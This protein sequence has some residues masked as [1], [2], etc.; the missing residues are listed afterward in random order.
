LMRRGQGK[1][2]GH[3]IGLPGE[4]DWIFVG[5]PDRVPRNAEAG[6]KLTVPSTTPAWSPLSGWR[7]R[8]N[9]GNTNIFSVLGK[10][11]KG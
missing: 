9:E 6:D 1:P 5:N 11:R 7:W 2:G 4:H 10:N 8:G 3:D